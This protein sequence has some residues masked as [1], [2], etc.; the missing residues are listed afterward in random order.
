MKRDIKAGVII[1]GICGASGSGKTTLANELQKH[2]NLPNFAVIHADNFNLTSNGIPCA[3]IPGYKN[4]ERPEI[5]DTKSLLKSIQQVTKE[6]EKDVNGRKM[7][8]VEGFVLFCHEYLMKY[9]TIKIFLEVS[10]DLCYI[11]RRDRSK[12][13]R[14]N[15]DLQKYNQ[16]FERYIWPGHLKHKEMFSDLLHTQ[17]TVIDSGN[18]AEYVLMETLLTINKESEIF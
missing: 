5:L 4:W 18:T 17:I 3:D 14:S 11:R 10:K 12:K 15:V 13:K 1:V 8:I 16:Y 6:L 2:F 9:F 7:M